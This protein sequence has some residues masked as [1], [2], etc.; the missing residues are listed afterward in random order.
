MGTG[1]RCEM[2]A[3]W[4]RRLEF[5]FLFFFE[6]ISEKRG[7]CFLDGA[8]GEPQIENNYESVGERSG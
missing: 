4:Q 2:I 8:G 7:D 5:V 6:T 1:G 3:M